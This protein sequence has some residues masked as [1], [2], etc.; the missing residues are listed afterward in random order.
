MFGNTIL[1]KPTDEI[2]GSRGKALGKKEYC[3]DAKMGEICVTSQMMHSLG[4]RET[5]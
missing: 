3:K 2:E 5:L 1:L 4:F